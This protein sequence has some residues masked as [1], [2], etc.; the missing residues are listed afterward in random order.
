MNNIR[1]MYSLGDSPTLCENH[2]P[3]YVIWSRSQ[4]CTTVPHLTAMAHHGVKAVL[5]VQIPP[6]H[7]VVLRTRNSKGERQEVKMMWSLINFNHLFLLQRHALPG[8]Q[9]ILVFD[10]QGLCDDVFVSSKS[11]QTTLV[12][13]VPHNH[14]CVLQE[15][16]LQMFVSHCTQVVKDHSVVVYVHFAQPNL[17]SIRRR[18]INVQTSQPALPYLGPSDEPCS[19]YIITYHCDS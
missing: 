14:I 8:D 7:K 12:D 18:S 4:N 2:I 19:Q 17:I 15:K 13:D 9:E 11:V 3:D 1:I 16:C 6:L 10:E 5:C